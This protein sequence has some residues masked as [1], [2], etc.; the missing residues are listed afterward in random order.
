VVQATAPAPPP[1]IKIYDAVFKPVREKPLEAWR[2]GCITSAVGLDERSLEGWRRACERWL[3]NNQDAEKVVTLVTS[4]REKFQPQVGPGSPGN[5][6]A[7]APPPPEEVRPA[8][9]VRIVAPA[10]IRHVLKQRN[11]P[12]KEAM[13]AMLATAE[14][15]A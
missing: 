1:Q 4:Y 13:A 3:G 2:W 8:E 14:V 7:A 6:S 5:V 12:L 15:V 10:A 9:P 11:G